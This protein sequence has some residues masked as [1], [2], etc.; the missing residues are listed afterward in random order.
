MLDR[1]ISTQYYYRLLQSSK[2]EAVIAEIV[3]ETEDYFI[4]LV[5]SPFAAAHGPLQT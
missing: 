1:N 2:K 5:F 4:D 3:T